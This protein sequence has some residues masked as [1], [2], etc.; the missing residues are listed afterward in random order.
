MKIL[1]KLFLVLILG[2]SFRLE[3]AGCEDLKDCVSLVSDITGE[4]YVA[5]KELKGKVHLSDNFKIHKKNADLFLSGALNENG[6]TRIKMKTGEWKIINVR[7]VRY[8]MEDTVEYGKDKIPHNYD[9]VT[10]SFKLKNKY[11]TGELTRS[12]RPFLSR[13]GRILDVKNANTVIINDTGIGVHK[14]AK[15]IKLMDKEL[16]P[17]ELKKHEES[18]KR[19]HDIKMVKAKNCT[20]I[21]EKLDRISKQLS[22]KNRSRKHKK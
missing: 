5:F 1:P 20:D 14:F 3:A 21:E 16:T 18:K 10:A 12:F 2:L 7:D 4:K 9:Y 11:L 8:S 17:E 15:M 6:Y 19:W 22:S 13:Y